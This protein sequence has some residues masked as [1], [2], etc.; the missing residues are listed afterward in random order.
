MRKL[1]LQMQL[2]IDGFVAGAEGEMDWMQWNWDDSLKEYV[3]DIT[4]PVDT[5]LLGRKLAGGFIPVWTERDNDPATSDEFTTKM[6]HAPK[7]VFTRTMTRCSWDHTELVHGDLV[8]M[9]NVLKE[10]EGGDLIVYGGGNFV[11]SLISNGLIDEYHLFINPT[12][13]GSG[14]RIFDQLDSSRRLQLADCR[15]FE[16]G[17][18]VLKYVI[19]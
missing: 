6:V 9:V 7:Y 14:M 4:G 17:I 8:R 3:N 2:S 15:K 19:A 5:I 10:Q 18:A 11:G 13:I 1:K 12:A 16:C